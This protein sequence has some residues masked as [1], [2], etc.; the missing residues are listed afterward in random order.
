M[1]KLGDMMK[2]V[3]VG[4]VMGCAVGVVGTCYMRKNKKGIKHNAGRAL[5]TIGDLME[6]ITDMF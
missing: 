5:H 4:M 2:G 1:G 3:G 6:S